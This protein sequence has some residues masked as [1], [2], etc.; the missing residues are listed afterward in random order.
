MRLTCVILLCLKF[1]T[2]SIWKNGIVH[3]AINSKDYDT[4][5]QDIIM[6]TFSQIQNEICI[7]FFQA[8]MNL[9]TSNG[10]RI[11]YISNPDKWKHCMPIVYDFSKSVID[12]PI[13]YKCLNQKDIARIVVEMLKASINPNGSA[14]NSFDL[15]KKFEDEDSQST[16]TLL[17]TK[18]R[19]YINSM[20]Q[21]ECGRIYQPL[22]IIQRRTF[23]NYS[24][25]P[26]INDENLD[27]YSDKLWP[28]GIVMCGIDEDLKKSEDYNTL[29][30][31][32]TAIA[33]FTCVSF[34]EI[35]DND[36]LTEKNYIWFGKEGDDMPLFGYGGGK[37]EIKLSSF[38]RGA[39]GHTG[40]VI[41]NL[42][43]IL[44]VHMMSNR[45]DRDNYV[46]INWKNVEKGKEHFL[47]KAPEAAWIS[48]IPYDFSSVSHASAN[49]MCGNCDLG[50][51]TV[52]PMQDRLWH[53]TLSM[54]R[55]N[56]LS[57]L[58]ILSIDMLYHSQC[59]ERSTKRRS[60]IKQ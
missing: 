60:E 3:Y 5:S 39:P 25:Y 13:G 22:Q 18:N 53:R 21:S 36:E 48:A 26:L 52:Q 11:L 23:D 12:M 19:N 27:Y 7:K 32:M 41:N 49:Y 33:R 46:I 9:N 20:Y 38:L 16:D 28:N 35:I 17:S 50:Q 43:R 54:G 42:L 15:L 34:Q 59:G 14:I 29:Q 40:H 31:A 44:G 24:E 1:V 45:Y 58:D 57:E 30:D 37:Q 56:R 2:G 4:H 55:V 47:E 8:Q 10:D 51:T 6:T